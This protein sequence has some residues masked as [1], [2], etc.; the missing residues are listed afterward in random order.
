MY[1][2]LLEWC[3]FPVNVHTR[4]GNT[5]GGDPNYAGPVVHKG[6]LVDEM[7]AITDKHGEHYIST[8]RVYFPP[9]VPVTVEDLLSF[10]SGSTYE[11]RKLGGF[12]D[13]NDGALSVL[14]VYL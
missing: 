3:R 11:V 1:A 5:A 4:I 10:E 7:V 2:S 9:T 8:S 12:Y 13:G 6:Y 14:V